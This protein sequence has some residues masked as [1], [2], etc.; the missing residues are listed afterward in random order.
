VIGTVRAG[1]PAAKA[2]VESGDVVVSVNGKPVTAANE[3]TAAIAALRPGDKATL[4]V[5]RDGSTVTLTVTLGTRPASA[6]A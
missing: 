2:G 4:K 3:L 5:Q 6:T 1:S